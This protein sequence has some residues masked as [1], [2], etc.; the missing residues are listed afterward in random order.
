MFLARQGREQR[1]A[2][3]PRWVLRPSTSRRRVRMIEKIRPVA[4]LSCRK[5]ISSLIHIWPSRR[6]AG[7]SIP[8]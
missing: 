7:A 1:Q 8:K 3:G 2:S 4:M 5:L 6:L